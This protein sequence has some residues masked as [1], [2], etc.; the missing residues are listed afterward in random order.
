MI[1]KL[2]IFCSF[3]CLSLSCFT[4]QIFGD[5]P[6]STI[7]LPSQTTNH[8]TC[9]I[10]VDMSINFQNSL[11]DLI[12]NMSI[13]SNSTDCCKQCINIANCNYFV[14]QNL[15][16][17]CMMYSN[18]PNQISAFQTNQGFQSGFFYFD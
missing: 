8:T 6:G 3:I 13:A 15:S 14:F 18:M 1:I 7:V 4:N 10:F 9:N 16:H 12:Q 11:S 17:D 2:I 5:L